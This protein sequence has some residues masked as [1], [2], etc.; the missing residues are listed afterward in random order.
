MADCLLD[1]FVSLQS[2]LIPEKCTSRIEKG[3]KINSE[4][5]K[6]FM[7]MVRKNMIVEKQL[8]PVRKNVFIYMITFLRELLKHSQT[9]DLTAD[10]LGMCF[11]TAFI[12]NASKEQ[13][14][15]KAYRVA[16]EMVT[17][18]L[19]YLLKSSSKQ[20]SGEVTA[21]AEESGSE[22]SDEE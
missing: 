11:S 6:A 15:S 10:F 20:I 17:E 22:A 21:P 8:S 9:N 16:Q 3:E 1:W 13:Q 4:F 2:P 19:I 18:L 7:S 12:V 5:V 14:L